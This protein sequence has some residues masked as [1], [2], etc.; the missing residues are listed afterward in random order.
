MEHKGAKFLLALICLTLL[1][2]LPSNI[3]FYAVPGHPVRSALSLISLCLTV[4]ALLYLIYQLFRPAPGPD[5]MEL[6]KKITDLEMIILQ[7]DMDMQL[8]NERL[9]REM[10]TFENA[11]ENAEEARKKLK[12]ISASLESVREEERS[13]ISREIH[14]ELGQQL[15]GLKMDLAWVNKKL[16]D[17]DLSH[18]MRSMLDLVDETI[19]TVR[20]ISTELRPRILDDLGL[21]A[22]IEWQCAE[23]TRRTSIPCRFSHDTDDEEFPKNISTAVFRIVQEA[24]T[25]A[26]RHSQASKI[27][28]K[29][30]RK[31]N[32]LLLS[33][34][35]NGRGINEE[36]LE[37]PHSFGIFGIRE[38]AE[39][40][41]G[42]CKITGE[43][44][45]GTTIELDLPLAA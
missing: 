39:I 41:G 37:N 16:Q 25:N 44:G 22:A 11:R 9:E 45:K 8:L 4:I 43:K 13:R 21:T 32:H 20:K 6:Q 31:Q 35:D 15:T 17:A 18:K 10:K 14:D 36:E 30:N 23:F 24:L 42:Q 29:L 33:I 38:R 12:K 2:S 1:L 3:E 28:V 27:H 7:K 26:I 19:G 34:H 5:R 40:L